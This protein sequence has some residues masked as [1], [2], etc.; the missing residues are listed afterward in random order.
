MGGR[1]VLLTL[2]MMVMGTSDN[3]INLILRL[4]TAAEAVD[5]K[6]RPIVLKVSIEEHHR[7]LLEGDPA[8]LLL[9]LA[10]LDHNARMP[11]LNMLPSTLILPTPGEVGPY[12][13]V[14]SV[15][16]GFPCPFTDSICLPSREVREVLLGSRLLPLT[17]T[18]KHSKS[19]EKLILIAKTMSRSLPE[20]CHRRT[21]KRENMMSAIARVVIRWP[22]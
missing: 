10:L 14:H 11:I 19:N 22:C 9:L 18:M 12:R 21:P 15:L 5:M 8:L 7:S 4:R 2:L 16:L 3:I 6:L 17:M 1:R 13:R 20:H